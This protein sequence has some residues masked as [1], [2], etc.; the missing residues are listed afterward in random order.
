MS[1]DE[2]ETAWATAGIVILFVGAFVGL[3]MLMQGGISSECTKQFGEGWIGKVDTYGPDFC[4]NDKGE[5]KF[6]R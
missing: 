3:L 5:A 2:K 6:P 1:R 4:V